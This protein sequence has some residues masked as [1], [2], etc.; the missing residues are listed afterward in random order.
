MD[1]IKN[2]IM[3][4]RAHKTYDRNKYIR[5]LYAQGDKNMAEIGREHNLTRQM[6]RKIIM[7]AE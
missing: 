3:Q 6:I 7:E 5:W 1:K 2:S 4:Q